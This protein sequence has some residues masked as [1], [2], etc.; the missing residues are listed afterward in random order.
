MCPISP[1][2]IRRNLMKVSEKI[3]IISG[4][5]GRTLL[6]VMVVLGLFSLVGCSNASGGGGS[7]DGSS[8]T[9][10]FVGAWE[11]SIYGTLTFSANGSVSCSKLLPPTAYT[12]SYT[13]DGST[14][15]IYANYQGIR[16][17]TATVTLNQDGTLTYNLSGMR[18]TFT[19][20][21]SSSIKK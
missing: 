9:N 19:K 6:L 4:G 11:N 10:A 8:S 7:G 20:Q 2:F 3:R 14:A 12:Y 18:Y 16:Q 15:T 13:V 17:P 5:G 1:Q 21:T